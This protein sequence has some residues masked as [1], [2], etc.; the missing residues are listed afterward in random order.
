MKKEEIVAVLNEVSLKDDSV[1]ALAVRPDGTEIQF[2]LTK[3]PINFSVVSDR[4]LSV[5]WGVRT[6]SKGDAYIYNRDVKNGEKVSLH[7]SG[8]QHIAVT[9]ETAIRVGATTRFGPK[10]IEPEFDRGAVPTFSILFP[11]WGVTKRNPE[12]LAKGKG[13]LLIAGHVEKV[14]VVGFFVMDAGLNLWVNAP[15]FVLGKLALR[16]GKTLHIVAWK[17][18]EGDL[19]ELLRASFEKVSNRLPEVD[20]LVI[21]FQGFRASDSAFMVAVPAAALR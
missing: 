21:D 2:P 7:A 4:G 6:G 5:Q 14:V 8:Q 10:W 13:E 16:P 1:Q 9:D 12:N 15:H 18:P 11:P 17:E 3:G 19:R 20:D